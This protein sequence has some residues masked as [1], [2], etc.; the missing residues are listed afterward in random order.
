MDRAIQPSPFEWTL[1]ALLLL[2]CGV[3]LR[4]LPKIWSGESTYPELPAPWWPWG[5]ALWRGYVRYIPVGLVNFVCMI[6]I[7][8]LYASIPED[9]IPLV[10]KVVIVL[11]ALQ[12]LTRS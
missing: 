12:A 4:N 10:V 11:W 6:G 9:D 7:Y 1:A 2:A 5:K 3:G 8:F